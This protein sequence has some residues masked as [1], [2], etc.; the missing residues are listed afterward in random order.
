[1]AEQ[2]LLISV[3][4]AERMTKREVKPTELVSKALMLIQKVEL[5][6]DLLALDLYFVMN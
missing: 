3:H 5:L 2:D 4:M 1:M 6:L